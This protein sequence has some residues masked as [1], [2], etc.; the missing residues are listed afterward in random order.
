MPNES[1]PQ[2]AERFEVPHC[3]LDQTLLCI[4]EFL[5]S[6]PVELVFN[7]DEIEISE[8]EDRKAKK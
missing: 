1:S 8:W 6:R 2:E 5:Q 7:L 3:F 4:S